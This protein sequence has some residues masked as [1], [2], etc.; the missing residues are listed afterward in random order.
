V[1]AVG[2]LTQAFLMVSG[3]AR[4]RGTT[5]AQTDYGRESL[6][7]SLAGLAMTGNSPDAR[8]AYCARA[9]HLVLGLADTHHSIAGRKDRILQRGIP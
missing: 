4:E 5:D 8:S 3:G 9:I 6:A 7:D 1:A 2:E